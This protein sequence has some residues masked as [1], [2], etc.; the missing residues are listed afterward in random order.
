M[1]SL[2]TTRDVPVLVVSSATSSERRINPSWTVSQLKAKLESVTG[3][4]PSAQALTLRLPDRQQGTSISAENEDVTKL[5]AWSL[6]AYAEIHVGHM[7]AFG[8]RT[9]L[10]Y[11]SRALHRHEIGLTVRDERR[12]YSLTPYANNPK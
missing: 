7:H 4:P 6:S 1:A 11:A 3:I 8:R 5:E 12:T 10:A 2:A 9:A